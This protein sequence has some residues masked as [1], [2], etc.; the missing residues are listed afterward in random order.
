MTWL[1]ETLLEQGVI[2][3]AACVTATGAQE[4]RFGYVMC[5]DSESVQGCAGSSYAAVCIADIVKAMREE[6]G[7]WAVV[8]VPC[9]AKGVRSLARIDSRI[10]ES[11]TVLIGL[12]CGQTKT[13]RFPDWLRRSEG[14]QSGTNVRFRVK[15]E[16]RPADD[17]A[18]IFDDDQMTRVHW[19]R[20]VAPVWHSRLFTPPACGVCDDVF[21]ETADVVAMDAWLPEF[22]SD[23][24][25]TSLLG[26]R[27]ARV[28][29]V[30]SDMS[31][32][33]DGCVLDCSPDSLIR[34]QSGALW[35]KRDGLQYR[36]MLRERDGHWSPPKRL[37]PARTGTAFDRAVWRSEMRSAESSFTIIG[38]AFSSPEAIRLGEQL[39]ARSVETRARRRF[40]GSVRSRAGGLIRR[41]L[42]RRGARHDEV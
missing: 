25:G 42:G 18:L 26:V 40:A 36:L 30:V 20:T 13:D 39:V 10:A 23:W 11:L 28:R 17:F 16:S 15:D 37:P 29:A 38:P 8:A 32:S 34:S 31:A 27:S 22:T 33:S 35:E 5:S 21:A 3:R 24:R 4:P 7:A 1:I 12:T 19:R 9:V 6:G 14:I 41:L 2:D